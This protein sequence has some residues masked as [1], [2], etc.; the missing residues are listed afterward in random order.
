MTTCRRSRSCHLHDT[1]NIPLEWVE[2]GEWA[3]EPVATGS[4]IGSSD[5][6]PLSPLGRTPSALM[7]SEVGYHDS[8][9]LVRLP[10]DTIQ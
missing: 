6:E 1:S 9:A 5:R 7:V 10:H 2:M 8:N 4:Q 3:R